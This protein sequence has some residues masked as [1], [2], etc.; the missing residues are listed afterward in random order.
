MQYTVQDV[1]K[2]FKIFFYFQNA[3]NLSDPEKQHRLNHSF[4]K[5]LALLHKK[6]AVLYGPRSAT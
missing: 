2:L 5:W 4:A 6:V 3:T 1:I